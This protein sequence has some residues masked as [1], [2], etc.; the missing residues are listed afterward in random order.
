MDSS[1]KSTLLAIVIICSVF[2]SVLYAQIINT[3]IHSDI[4]LK[5]VF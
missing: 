5:D 2:L 3:V 1:H 4:M